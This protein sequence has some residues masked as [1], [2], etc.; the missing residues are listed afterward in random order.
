MTILRRHRREAAAPST[1]AMIADGSLLLATERAKARVGDAVRTFA[2]AVGGGCTALTAGMILGAVGPGQLS[3]IAVALA[4][5]AASI[6]VRV[7]KIQAERSRIAVLDIPGGKAF[8]EKV[9]GLLGE[10]K[11]ALDNGSAWIVFDRPGSRPEAMSERAYR[12]YR[13][14]VPS[15]VEVDATADRMWIARRTYGELDSV[16]TNRPALQSFDHAGVAQAEGWYVAGRESDENGVALARS[17]A[18]PAPTY[19]EEAFAPRI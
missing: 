2:D 17:M 4:G 6:A 11:V 15:L 18:G 16:L 9:L 14:T 19:E 13:K 5:M 1:R 12:D 10:G 8:S 7:R 3:P